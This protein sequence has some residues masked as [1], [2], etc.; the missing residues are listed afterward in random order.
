MR[1]AS[2]RLGVAGKGNGR[3]HLGGDGLRDAFVALVVE[4][5]RRAQKLDPALGFHVR[6]GRKGRPGRADG[7]R[8]VVRAA[9]RDF[10]DRFLRRG[11]Y[12]RPG[13]RSKRIVPDAVDVEFLPVDFGRCGEHEASGFVVKKC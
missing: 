6:I 13:V 5:L 3:C 12:D 9:H 7:P 2:Q 8:N 1:L 11:I 10:G 4:L